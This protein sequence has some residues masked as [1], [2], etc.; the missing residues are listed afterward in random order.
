[1]TLFLSLVKDAEMSSKTITGNLH[2]IPADENG[3]NLPFELEKMSAFAY[4]EPRADV[5][6]AVLI[7]GLAGDGSDSAVKVQWV[8]GYPVPETSAGDVITVLAAQRPIATIT[9]TGAMESAGA[10]AHA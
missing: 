7:R 9:V 1:L 5:E 10:D 3:P 6:G 2:W 4:V 8:P